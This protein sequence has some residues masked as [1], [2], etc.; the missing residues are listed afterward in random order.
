MRRIR[1]IA[2]VAGVLVSSLLGFWAGAK[3]VLDLIG[4]ALAAED[5]S[6][7]DGLVA[8][9]ALWL[10]NTPWWVPAILAVAAVLG[11]LLLIYISIRN[12]T[13]NTT[14]AAKSNESLTQSRIQR[15]FP[16]TDWDKPLTQIFRQHYKNETVQLDGKNF[17]EC[18]FENVTFI[19]QGTRPIQMMN[20]RKIPQEGFLVTVQTDNPVVFTALGIMSATGVSGP[21]ELDLRSRDM[22]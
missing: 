4:R 1:R 15:E 13:A 9:G 11:V 12:G 20:C 17:V 3:A 18:T 16:T 10:F 14:S 6:K 8:R 21:I 19:Y 22:R 5:F 7:P 2:A